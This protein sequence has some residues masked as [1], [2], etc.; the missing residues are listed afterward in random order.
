MAKK[1]ESIPIRETDTVPSTEEVIEVPI[2]ETTK[3]EVILHKVK[4]SLGRDLIVQWGDSQKILKADEIWE[5]S[6][7]TKDLDSLR[8]KLEHLKVVNYV[9]FV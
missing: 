4:N 7:V 9:N 1:Q 8:K 3:K 5:I 6:D 2:E